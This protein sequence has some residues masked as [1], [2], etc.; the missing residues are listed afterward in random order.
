MNWFNII[1]N[2]KLRVGSK[3]TTNLGSTSDNQPDEPCKKK[4][5]DY[6][7][8]LKN[9]KGVLTNLDRAIPA[10]RL[11]EG[12]RESKYGG[13]ISEEVEYYLDDT[14]QESSFYDLSFYK[15]P[16]EVACKALKMFSEMSG[17]STR[18][19]KQIGNNY[20]CE[21]VREIKTRPDVKHMRFEVS[22]IIMI[23]NR[24]GP[25]VLDFSHKLY[26]PFD[27][28]RTNITQ[29]SMLLDKMDWR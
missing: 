13:T 4:L 1:K 6:R 29:H 17:N 8:K 22:L 7:E 23:N 14:T 18:L 25:V 20:W 2:P 11:R 9:I 24:E 15:L 21:V 28:M 5:L 16:E 19:N 3:V 10:F 26:V 27:E 12:K